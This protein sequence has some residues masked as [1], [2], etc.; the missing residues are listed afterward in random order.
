MELQEAV[1]NL[2]EIYQPI[3]GHEEAFGSSSRQC[4]DRL[5]YIKKV[6][7]GLQTKL[8]RTIKVLDLGCAQGFFS[9]SLAAL[10]A[11]VTGVDALKENID[12]CRV[13]ASEHEEFDVKFVNDKIENVI[14][15]IGQDDYDIVLGLSVFHHLCYFSDFASVQAM[16]SKLATNIAVGIYEF[17]LKSE[18]VYWNTALPESYRDFVSCYTCVKIMDEFPTHLSDVK[19]PFV[20]ASNRY[21]LQREQELLRID[22]VLKRSHDLCDDTINGTRRYFFA[23]GMFI[24]HVL[25]DDKKGN[26]IIDDLNK[27][28]LV[29]EFEFLTDMNGSGP[30]PRIINYEINEHEGWLM[31]EAKDGELLYKYM[32]RMGADMDAWQEIMKQ[33]LAQMVE[34][35]RMGWYHNDVR[36]WNVLRTPDGTYQFID[37]GSMVR[38]K[39]DCVWPYDLVLSFAIFMYEVATRTYRILPLRFT[40]FHG[41]LR[42]ILPRHKV[43]EIFHISEDEHTFSKLY[44]IIFRENDE[45]K[46]EEKNDD[47]YSNYIS[48]M[49]DAHEATL[50]LALTYH[51]EANQLLDENKN[52]IRQAEAEVETLRHDMET[53]AETLRRDMETEVETLRRDMEEK[54]AEAQ[55][56]L[57]EQTQSLVRAEQEVEG[58]KNSVSWRITKPL[59]ALKRMLRG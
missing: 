22:K 2:P 46:T 1:K 42:E 16:I 58:M 33:V 48:A 21:V 25:F 28:E 59:R 26:E 50:N 32:E 8:G 3:Y 55:R 49:E 51:R 9:L 36:I 18:P 24:K 4:A 23:E 43:N 44:E 10:G 37:Y 40:K 39:K 6:Y 47:V 57:A 7:Q 45:S 14:A 17:A 53:Q 56:K 19:R 29:N 54:S 13:L 38:E 27:R 31:R 20:Y 5:V 41:M 30:W 35:E 12:V 34:L 52:K 15:S 11:S